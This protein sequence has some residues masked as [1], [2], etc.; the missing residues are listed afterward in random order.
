M[1]LPPALLLGITNVGCRLLCF[2][3]TATHYFIPTPFGSARALRG[4]TK[5][6][7][8]G[9]T[10]SSSSAASC[11]SF[12]CLSVCMYLLSPVSSFPCFLL[13]YHPSFFLLHYLLQHAHTQHK[14]NHSGSHTP[15]LLWG[16]RHYIHTHTKPT[17]FLCK[18]KGGRMGISCTRPTPPK[19]EV[20]GHQTPLLPSFHAMGEK[21]RAPDGWGIIWPTPPGA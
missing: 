21:P 2:G 8:E 17:T 12:S 15:L 18:H 20:Q 9:A 14:N 1:R 13:P 3:F 11:S 10:L 6:V 7:W 4:A 16:V 5:T 19:Y